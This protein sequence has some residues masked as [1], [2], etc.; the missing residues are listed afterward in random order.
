[1]LRRVYAF[2]PQVI[3]AMPMLPPLS[4]L[5][6]RCV[7]ADTLLDYAYSDDA[8]RTL[9]PGF[10]AACRCYAAD[11]VADKA[12]HAIFLPPP[13]CHCHIRHTYAYRFAYAA[14]MI[15]ADAYALIYD[16]S[17]IY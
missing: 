16:M 14:A 8:I 10:H 12:C 2:M 6:C 17:I 13:C 5:P 15:R 7:A 1:M 11:V 3:C 9:S 4:V